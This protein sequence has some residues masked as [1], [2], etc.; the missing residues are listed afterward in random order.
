MK[1]IL[2][3]IIVFFGS[4]VLADAFGKTPEYK[5]MVQNPNDV[6]STYNKQLAIDLLTAGLGNGNL[7][8]VEAI[9]GNKYIQHNPTVPDGKKAFIDLVNQLAKDGRQTHFTA[10]FKRVIAED[11]RVALHYHAPDFGV[12]PESSEGSAIVDFFRI[13]NGKIVEH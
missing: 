11:N 4:I 7:D 8:L 6:L 1:H 2:T 10:N 12:G 13:E 3:L 9:I 5:R